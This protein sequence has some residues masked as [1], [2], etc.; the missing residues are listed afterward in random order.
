MKAKRLTTT[1]IGDTSALESALAELEQLQ[2]RFGVAIEALL[3]KPWQEL[4]GISSQAFGNVVTVKFQ[5]SDY[6]RGVIDALK[7]THAN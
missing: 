3:E 2:S 6:L 1:F 7:V 4:F 5:P